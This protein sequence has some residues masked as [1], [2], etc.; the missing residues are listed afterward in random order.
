MSNVNNPN[1]IATSTAAL[2]TYVMGTHNWTI[3]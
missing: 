2:K 1:I 3:R